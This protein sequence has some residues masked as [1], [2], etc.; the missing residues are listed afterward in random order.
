MAMGSFFRQKSPDRITISSPGRLIIPFDELRQDY[1]D[2]ITACYFEKHW[3]A[4]LVLRQNSPDHLT[5][6]LWVSKHS[7]FALFRRS[8]AIIGNLVD[9]YA[10][11]EGFEVGTI[12]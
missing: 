4:Q 1:L 11:R 8:L 10:Y 3:R 12:L 5:I 9:I 6:Q 7:I 2:L